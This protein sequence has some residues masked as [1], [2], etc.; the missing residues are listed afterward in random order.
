MRV[1]G[2]AVLQRGVL[3]ERPMGVAQWAEASAVVLAGV[4]RLRLGCASSG[5]LGEGQASHA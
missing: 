1:P 5:I 3:R 4:G 2:I